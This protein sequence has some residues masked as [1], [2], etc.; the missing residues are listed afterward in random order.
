ML[1]CSQTGELLL[2]SH[3]QGRWSHFNCTGAWKLQGETPGTCN[4]FLC[5]SF[6]STDSL[7]KRTSCGW[8]KLNPFHWYF[9]NKTLQVL[10]LFFECPLCKA[11]NLSQTSASIQFIPSR[12]TYILMPHHTS[13]PA[14][15]RLPRGCV[16]GSHFISIYTLHTFSGPSYLNGDQIVSASCAICWELVHRHSANNE[17]AEMTAL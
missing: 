16:S 1:H 2:H 10:W 8:G 12:T 7:K 17:P 15:I 6:L 13:L 4:H 3:Q 9:M 14:P 5:L 11:L